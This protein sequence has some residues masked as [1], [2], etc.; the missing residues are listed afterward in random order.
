MALPC[1]WHAWL[2]HLTDAPETEKP[3]YAKPFTDNKT[4]TKDIYVPTGHVYNKLT[5]SKGGVRARYSAWN[6]PEGV[7]A[8]EINARRK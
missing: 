5:Q 6:G 3:A 4:L 8:E 2:H 1:S 7:E